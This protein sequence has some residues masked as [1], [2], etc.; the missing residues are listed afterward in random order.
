L[1]CPI[2]EKK[3]YYFIGTKIPMIQKMAKYFLIAIYRFKIVMYL[4]KVIPQINGTT[5]LHNKVPKDLQ[6]EKSH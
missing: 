1:I 6:K 4:Q 2:K 5:N 3:G